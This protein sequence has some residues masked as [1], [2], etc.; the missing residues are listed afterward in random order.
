M[1][2]RFSEKFS[3]LISI[4]LNLNHFRKKEKNPNERSFLNFL[5]KNS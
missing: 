2:G 5:G 1:N 4:K 3:I